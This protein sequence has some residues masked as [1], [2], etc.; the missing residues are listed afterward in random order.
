MKEQNKHWLSDMK[1]WCVSRRLMTSDNEV[2]CACGLMISLSSAVLLQTVIINLI[3]VTSHQFSFFVPFQSCHT[4]FLIIKQNNHII[5]SSARPWGFLIYLYF[6]LFTAFC[7]QLTGSLHSSQPSFVLHF[8][9]LLFFFSRAL[10]VQLS[11]LSE[12]TIHL[13]LPAW[14]A[15][16]GSAESD[17]MW[18]WQ[19][20]A[21]I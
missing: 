8:S 19:A 4:V 2:W 20:G 3:Y 5:W 11:A 9:A 10:F 21:L 6:T 17:M 1:S 15:T 14:R 12:E 18:A 7:L 16:L 13:N